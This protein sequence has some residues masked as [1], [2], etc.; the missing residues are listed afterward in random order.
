MVNNVGGCGRP[1]R[2]DI[3]FSRSSARNVEKRQDVVACDDFAVV[4]VGID[5]G[6]QLQMTRLD[7]RTTAVAI[8]TQPLFVYVSSR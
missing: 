4:L 6:V 2:S 3:R 5:V 7:S 1:Y 8:I